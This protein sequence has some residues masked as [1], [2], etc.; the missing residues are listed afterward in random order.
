MDMYSK[1]VSVEDAWKIFESPEE[2]DEITMTVILW[3]FHIM[4]LRK[5]LFRCLLK[6]LSRDIEDS[7]KVFSQMSQTN[8]VSRNSLIVAFACHGDGSKAL[9]MY[10]EMRLKGIQP[11]DVTFLFLLLAWSHVGL[12]EKGLELL[13]S[14]AKDHG[15]CPSSE[16]YA[17]VVNLLGRD[18]FLKQNNSLLD[19]LTILE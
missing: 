15:L 13:E 12:V 6:L 8:W 3:V 10:E 16:H 1:C 9:Q 4:D 18:F 19:Y 2:L 11:T 5:N 7:I 17:C 14:M